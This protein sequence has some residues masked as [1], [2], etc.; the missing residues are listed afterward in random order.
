MPAVT[1]TTMKTSSKPSSSSILEKAVDVSTVSTPY[2]KINIYGGNRV[3]KTTLACTFPK[4]LL[5]ISFEL[6]E[7]GG[8]ESVADVQGVRFLQDQ[9]HFIGT[10]GFQALVEELKQDTLYKTAVLDGLTSMQD[11]ILA[12]LLGLEKLPE[13]QEFGGV[14]KATY[15]KRSEVMKEALRPFMGLKKNL[16]IL[17]KEKDHRPKEDKEKMDFTP[18]F[19]RKMGLDSYYASEVGGSIAGWVQDV[20]PYITRMFLAP[21][22]VTKKIKVPGT[23]KEIDRTEETGRTVHRLRILYHPNFATGSRTLRSIGLPEYLDEPDYDKIVKTYKGT[24]F[25]KES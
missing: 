18:A 9:K 3:G 22:T 14:G 24:L 19:L 12:E 16:V 20:C 7:A 11:R 10:K 21:E 1:K 23:N 17:A 6:A 8:A 4:P 25:S 2:I 15:Q 5:L 13:Q